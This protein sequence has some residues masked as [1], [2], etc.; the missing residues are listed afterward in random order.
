L[1]KERDREPRTKQPHRTE[2]SRGL[3]EGAE[4]DTIAALFSDDVESHIS[5]AAK[6]RTI[7]SGWPVTRSLTVW[8]SHLENE[9]WLATLEHLVRL[10]VRRDRGGGQDELESCAARRV[11]GS[12]Q[13]ATV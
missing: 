2:A 3:G 8:D 10:C 1:N 5:L 9:G 12:P 13:A 7:H 4:P 11:V 6:R